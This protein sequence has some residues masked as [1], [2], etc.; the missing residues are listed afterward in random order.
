MAEKSNLQDYFFLI[1]IMLAGGHWL[2][3]LCN[4]PF[5]SPCRELLYTLCIIQIVVYAKNMEKIAN[6]FKFLPKYIIKRR[7]KKSI[8]KYI[9]KVSKSTMKKYE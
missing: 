2:E 1:C 7:N 6:F 5:G 8:K 3:L 4:V 9:E